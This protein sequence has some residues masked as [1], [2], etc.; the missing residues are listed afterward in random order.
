MNLVELTPEQ[1]TKLAG[2]LGREVEAWLRDH[3]VEPHYSAERAAELLEVTER[4]IWNYVD[5]YDRT[6]GRDG[7]GPYVKISH[8]VVRIPAS[9]V[10]RF[11]R[12]R[13][14]AAAKQNADAG[15]ASALEVAG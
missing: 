7:I 14:I 2:K 6:G 12:S 9:A 5:L 10:N 15:R 3:T 4:T 8:K 1:I 11:L 13:T